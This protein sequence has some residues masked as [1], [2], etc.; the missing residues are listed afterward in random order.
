MRNEEDIPGGGPALEV[1]RGTVFA[2]V[3]TDVIG[4]K[5]AQSELETG[6]REAWNNLNT[7]SSSDLRA[8]SIDSP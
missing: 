1:W 3:G 7:S 6:S 4:A 8:T 2:S 5:R